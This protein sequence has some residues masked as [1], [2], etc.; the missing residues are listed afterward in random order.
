MKSWILILSL[1]Y[2]GILILLSFRSRR[3]IK[4]ANDFIFAGSNIGVFLGFLT[5]AAT[6][7][8][9][10][11]LLG[12]P[13][14]FRVHGIG[15]WIFLAVSDGAMVFLIVWFGF[16]LRRKILKKGFNGI[17]GLL[18]NCYQTKLAG[19]VYFLGAFIFLIPYI[20]IQIRGVAI[21][22]NATFPEFLP[23]WGWA[24]LIVATM[25]IY[26][27]VGGLRAI[28]YADTLQ[29]LVLLIVVWIIALNCIKYIGNIGDLFREVEKA[30]T[31]LLSTPG[32]EGLFN[33]QFLLASFLA[34]LLIPVTQPQ[35]TIRLVLMRSLKAMHRMAVAVGFF[36]IIIILPTA[37][38][39]L[40]GAVNY[41]EASTADFLSRVLLFDQPGVI[42]AA[43]IIGLF[44]AA[45]STSDSQIFA[46]GSELRSLLTGNEK[47]LL[48]RTRI[49]MVIFAVAAMIFSILSSDELVLLARVSFAGTALMA[50]MIFAAILQKKS[51]G[52]EVVIFT[53]AGLILFLAS[54][55]ELI[56]AE[57]LGFRMD[58][59][60]LV[61]LGIITIFSILI[62]RFF[63]SS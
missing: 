53:L 58:M 56:P 24:V 40:Y 7:F 18:G 49:V 54:L 62:R 21:F 45:L 61:S 29:G 28:M 38:I 60:L 39:G 36:A 59:L 19:Y 46:L 48:L 55:F 17:S 31:L 20:A 13:D 4:T 25:L 44:A 43:A 14:F 23:V 51:P 6:L 9:T 10:F 11:T 22:L 42:G 5:F 3:K 37:A 16:H 26:S 52:F 63:I 32:P 41:P 30:D 57:L 33:V 15:A 2:L 47:I 1:L 27:E 12:M 50:P 35:L 8:S 34:I